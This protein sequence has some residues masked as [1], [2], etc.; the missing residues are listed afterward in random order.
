MKNAATNR[1]VQICLPYIIFKKNF[2]PKLALPFH[3]SF[4]DHIILDLTKTL[5]R[6]LIPMKE[7]SDL[8]TWAPPQKIMYLFCCLVPIT[9]Q[10]P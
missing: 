7:V 9:G 6:T 4:T 2:S 10:M 8:T 5:C 3:V 1:G